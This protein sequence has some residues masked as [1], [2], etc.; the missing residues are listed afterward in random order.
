MTKP[1]EETWTTGEGALSGALYSGDTWIGSFT[2]AKRAR[3]AVQAPK[4]AQ[5]LLYAHHAIMGDRDPG[6]AIAKIREAL[7]G[8]GVE[9][10]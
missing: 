10:P 2:D 6:T 4:M 5:A 8:T 7:S 9:L 3:L 1:H